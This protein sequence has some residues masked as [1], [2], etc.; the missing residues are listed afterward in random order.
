[1]RKHIPVLLKEVVKFL[2]CQPGGVYVDCTLGEG[3]HAEAILEQLGKEGKLIGIDQDEEAIKAAGQRLK[4]YGS[5]C[6]LVRDNFKNLRNILKNF[7]LREVDG[8]LF[9]LGVSSPQL[10]NPERGFSFRFDTSLDMRMDRRNPLTAS[11]LVNNLSQEKLEE[12]IRDFGEERWARRIAELI[13]VRRK[14]EPV[15]TTGQ[16]VRIVEEAIPHRRRRIHPATRTFQALRMVV[17]E[18]LEVLREGLEKGI[19]LLRSGGRMGVI[20][21][22]SLDDRIVKGIFQKW[23]RTCRCPPQWPVCRCSG[24]KVVVMVTKGVVRPGE[25]EVLENRRS[26]SARL[27]VVEKI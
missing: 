10:D 17:N 8:I 3:G 25:E 6:N 7:D 15:N 13:V 19:K 22:H 12:I 27:R 1:M 20:S 4:K 9:D 11:Y 18:E 26:R 21:Y 2:H 14:C 16:L 24:K 23:A 5:S